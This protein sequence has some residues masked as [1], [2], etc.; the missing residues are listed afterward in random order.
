MGEGG[1]FDAAYPGGAVRF[2]RMLSKW[3]DQGDLE[4]MDVA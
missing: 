4:G 3:R 2:Q 1:F